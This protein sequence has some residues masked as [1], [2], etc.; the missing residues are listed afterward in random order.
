MGGRQ[1]ERDPEVRRPAVARDQRA[2]RQG[3]RP[4]HTTHKPALELGLTFVDQPP[5]DVAVQRVAAPDH[6][7]LGQ[8]GAGPGD[9]VLLGHD[10]LPDQP[11]GLADIQLMRPVAGV[12]KLVGRQPP[13]RQLGL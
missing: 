4:G 8:G 5:T 2:I 9:A 3:V 11:P 1:T 7:L 13:S 12:L 6:G 10:R